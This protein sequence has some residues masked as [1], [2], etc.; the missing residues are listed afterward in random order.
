MYISTLHELILCTL[1][2]KLKSLQQLN[3]LDCIGPPR[4]PPPPTLYSVAPLCIG[5][6]PPIIW[7][8]NTSLQYVNC[9]NI[10]WMVGREGQTIATACNTTLV[11]YPDPPSTLH[12]GLGTRLYHLY[13]QKVA[14]F[15]GLSY[16]C[17][18]VCTQYVTQKCIILN[19]GLYSVCYTEVYYTEHWFVFGMQYTRKCITLNTGLYSVCY[20]HRS[21]LH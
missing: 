3:I 14:S 1:G 7:F 17:S 8:L 16:L 18:L 13:Q 15:P 21:V 4:P 12:G 6:L 9:S 5:C 10:N 11:S 2:I 20:I 19:T